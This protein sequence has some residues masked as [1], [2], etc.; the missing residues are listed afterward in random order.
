[1]TVRAFLQAEWSEAFSE[2]ALGRIDGPRSVSNGCDLVEHV[3][4][5]LRKRSDLVALIGNEVDFLRA[6]RNWVRALPEHVPADP[7]TRERRGPVGVGR[8]G[9]LELE[10][11]GWLILESTLEI[12][13]LE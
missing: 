13:R 1:M 10:A 5:D 9:D 7:D 4:K 11:V 3:D 12:E 6:R 8:V 2:D